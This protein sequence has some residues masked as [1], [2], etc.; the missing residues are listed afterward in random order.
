MNTPNPA[1]DVIT[2]LENGGVALLENLRFHPGE[3]LISSLVKAVW[4]FVWGRSLE[5]SNPVMSLFM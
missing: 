2:K 3:L 5:G 1:L 4:I